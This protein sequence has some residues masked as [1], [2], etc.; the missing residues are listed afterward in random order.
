MKVFAS[1]AF[2]AVIALTG[3]KSSDSEPAQQYD[4]LNYKTALDLTGRF[5]DLSVSLRSLTDTRC[6]QNVIC[7]QA[8]WVDLEFMV[9]SSTDSVR[10]STV[11]Y[12]DSGKDQ[13]KRFRLGSESYQLSIHRV[14]PLPAQGQ[15]LRIDEYTVELSVVR[16]ANQLAI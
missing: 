5:P 13:P 3:C 11:F 15:R 7:I 6:P 4:T 12:Q 8:G 14:L 1:L 10:V 2:L 16:D 9:K